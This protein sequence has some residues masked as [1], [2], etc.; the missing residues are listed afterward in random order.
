M[1][2]DRY[3]LLNGYKNK[4]WNQISGF[5]FLESIFIVPGGL[6]DGVEEENVVNSKRKKVTNTDSKLHASNETI[7]TIFQ[8]RSVNQRKK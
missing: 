8:K 4:D 2:M 5:F 1:R 7:M 3:K 6:I